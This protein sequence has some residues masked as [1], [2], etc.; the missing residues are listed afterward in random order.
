MTDM[1]FC[2]QFLYG[3]LEARLYV[4]ASGKNRLRK[5]LGTD[6]S[7]GDSVPEDLMA[8]RNFQRFIRIAVHY[9]PATMAT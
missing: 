2:C 1:C 8:G 7:C 5:G 9:H 4:F 6:S 3:C